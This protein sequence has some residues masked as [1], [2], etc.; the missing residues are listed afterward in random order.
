MDQK[1]PLVSIVSINF[2]QAKMTCEMIESVKQITYPNYEIIIV[3]NGSPTDKPEE[4]KE[5]FPEIKLIVSE[6][7]LGFAG[8]NNLGIKEASGDYILFLNNDTEV[9]PDFLEPLVDQCLSDPQIGLVSPKINYFFSENK[10]TIQYAGSI[11]INPSTGRGEKIGSFHFDK[12]QYNDIRETQ[13]GHGAAML[14]PTKV[15]KEVGLMP[16][17]FFLYY[18][19]HDWCEKIK[20]AGYKVWYVGTSTIYHKESMSVGKNSP[21]RMYYMTRGRLLYTRRNTR[22]LTKF[23]ALSFFTFLS[24]PKNTLSL[25][26]HT[27]FKLLRAFWAAVCWHVFHFNVQIIPKLSSKN[28]ENIIIDQTIETKVKFS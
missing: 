15:I 23:K 21:L 2:N 20:Q 17:I 5:Q 1:Y 14:I 3:D 28:G 10:K 18:E 6:T 16:D 24:I 9:E 8:G 13:L 27:E 11:G 12:G 7:N 22:G 4:I 19:E 26:I 25:I